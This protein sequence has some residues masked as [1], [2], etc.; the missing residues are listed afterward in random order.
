MKDLVVCKFAGCNQVYSDPR[1]LP[2]GKRTCAAH[3]EEMMVKNFDVNSNKEMI[4]CHFCEEIHTLPNNGKGFP[5]DENIHILLNMKHCAEHDAAKKSLNE[6]TKL[7]EKLSKLNKEEL[8]IDY[9]EKVETD[10]LH[11][12]ELNI[13]KLAA[14]YQKLVN[15]VQER[16]RKCLQNLKQ[17]GDLDAF[18]HKLMEHKSWLKKENLESI[19]I[20]L[21]GDDDTWK[22]IQ[23]TCNIMLEKMLTLEEDLNEKVVGDQRIQFRSIARKAHIDDIC[24]QLYVETIDSTI[25]DNYKKENALARLCKFREKEFKLIYRASR[26]GF[27]ASD[28]HAKCDNKSNTLTIIKTTKGYIFGGYIA[29]AWN[30]KGG[31]RADP[32]AFIFSLDNPDSSPKLFPVKVGDSCS[33]CCHDSYGPIFGNGHDICILNDSNTTTESYSSLGYSFDTTLLSGDITTE[34][35]LFLTGSVYF[36]TAEVEVFQLN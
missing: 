30:N 29:V 16:K 28:F 34:P 4:K 9:F 36:Q 1:F 17:E 23:L 15:R 25:V 20:T 32:N 24:G 21:D 5:V 7:L 13:Q 26:D 33:I 35:T 3:V 27:K 11:E 10:I 31:S 19:L 6:L 14:Y 2:C 12:K 8:V 18:D 22:R